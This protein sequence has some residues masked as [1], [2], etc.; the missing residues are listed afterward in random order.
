MIQ[1]EI[2]NEELCA[3]CRD[4]CCKVYLNTLKSSYFVDKKEGNFFEN[5]YE[6]YG[7]Y[8]LRN[9]EF[10]T[11]DYC[12]FHDS[13]IGCIIE[14]ERRPLGCRTHACDNLFQN[15]LE[16]RKIYFQE[17]QKPMIP[18]GFQIDKDRVIPNY[19]DID[20]HDFEKMVKDRT[21][22]CLSCEELTTKGERFACKKCGCGLMSRAFRVYPLDEEGKA[23]AQLMPNG[24]YHYVCPLKKW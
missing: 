12:E 13:S 6:Q 24:S 4:C 14:R 22:I 15:F 21:G 16:I 9:P 23:I 18:I 19:E 3:A 5:A 20:L 11:G 8:P 10:E 7:A 17:K 2:I 1:I